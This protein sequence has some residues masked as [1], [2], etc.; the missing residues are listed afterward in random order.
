MEKRN[1]H[2]YPIIGD[3]DLDFEATREHFGRG[4]C[5]YAISETPLSGGETAVYLRQQREGDAVVDTP[6]GP[7]RVCEQ[8]IVI[9]GYKVSPTGFLK[10]LRRPKIRTIPSTERPRVESELLERLGDRKPVYVDF[11]D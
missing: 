5:S 10:S 11:C 8:G 3:S 1:L 7:R 9:L 2:D 4:I 6:R